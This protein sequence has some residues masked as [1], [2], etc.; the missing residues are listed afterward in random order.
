[1]PHRITSDP[2]TFLRACRVKGQTKI[3]ASNEIDC[4]KQFSLAICLW[5]VG[6]DFLGLYGR[7]GGRRGKGWGIPLSQHALLSLSS[8]RVTIRSK[9]GGWRKCYFVLWAER[10]CRDPD[11]K[12][13]VRWEEGSCGDSSIAGVYVGQN[14]SLDA[15]TV[16]KDRA[17][18]PLIW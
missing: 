10:M 7:Q 1:M 15:S 11:S 4:R 5:R 13:V 18:R 12:N 2:F 16:T 17:G 9:D 3:V 6:V 14:K 8:Q